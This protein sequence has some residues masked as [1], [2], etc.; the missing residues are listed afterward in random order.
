MMFMVV[1][2]GFG[3]VST[4]AEAKKKANTKNKIEL[5]GIAS[6]DKIFK[7]ART[8]NK[9]L[10]SAEKNI[11]S[12]KRALRSALKLGKKATYMD[13]LKELKAK[14]KGKLKVVMVGGVPTLKAKEAIPSDI[15]AGID[16]VNRLT[17]TIPATIRDMKAVASASR[18][19]V[20]HS[21][22]LTKNLQKEVMAKSGSGLIT[23][24]FKLPKVAKTST[25][26]VRVITRMPGRAKNVSEDL[27]SI[28]NSLRKTF[29][30]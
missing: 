12:S 25:N 30:N 21:K 23:M 15:Q 28:S 18:K 11:R 27:G 5:T 3:M 2:L 22:D 4:D 17:K 7:K 13:G 20:K 9:K 6:F 19:M 8:A 29:K 10:K 24:V 16:A 14:A 1:F 26:N